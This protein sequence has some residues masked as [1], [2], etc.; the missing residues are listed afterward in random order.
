MQTLVQQDEQI[1]AVMERLSYFEGLHRYDL[2]RL[3]R[4]C[5]QLA[6]AE[7][8]TLC[9]KGGT[10][11][12]VGIVVSGQLKVTLP[13]PDGVE[14]VLAFVGRGESFGEAAAVMAAPNPVCVT[15]MRDSHVLAVERGLL[16]GEMARNPRLGLRVLG[17]VSQRLLD[18]VRD[19]ETC[20]IRSSVERVISYLRHRVAADASVDAEFEFPARKKEIA[21]NLSMTP[22]TFSRAL[23]TLTREGAIHMRGRRV[24]ILDQARLDAGWCRGS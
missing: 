14:K 22:E 7:G 10:V 20:H 24:R 5:C 19:T 13:L 2:F 6:V 1:M 21:A 23:H 12:Y 11:D 4:G 8:E 3:A 15:S 17:N 9:R 18:M 16:L